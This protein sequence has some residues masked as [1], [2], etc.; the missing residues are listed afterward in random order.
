MM[1]LNFKN[2]IESVL[3]LSYDPNKNSTKENFFDF[4][5]L[6]SM[7]M[8]SRTGEDDIS[9]TID[10]FKEI[11]AKWW[12]KTLLEDV[13]ECIQLEGRHIYNQVYETK[14][15][16]KEILIKNKANIHD[17]QS[18]KREVV[19]RTYKILFKELNWESSYGGKAWYDVCVL[20]EKLNNEN[21]IN[22][23]VFLTDR[24][25]D[26]EHN[27]DALLTKLNKYITWI[28]KALDFKYEVKNVREYQDYI[29]PNIEKLLLRYTKDRN[30]N[31]TTEEKANYSLLS[32]GKIKKHVG[33]M[34]PKD[35]YD[36]ALNNNMPFPDGEDAISKIP[37]FSYN[38][39]R[40]VIKGPFPKGEDAIATNAAYSFSYARSVIKGP[41]PKGE[42]A[43]SKDSYYSYLYAKNILKAP[44]PKGEKEIERTGDF[45]YEYIKMFPNSN[46][47]QKYKNTAS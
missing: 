43:I 30:I 16:I 40:Y 26:T 44:F 14:D 8:P 37:D 24:I 1:Q 33:K 25:F 46:L 28:K 45:K 9:H 18:Q 23:I 15:E 2:F 22:Q 29:S 3:N 32:K 38:Y 7:Y 41:F 11:N 34:E 35:A 4:Y 17:L 36:Y 47:A 42:D 19:V 5:A 20:W 21:N 39:A 27:T 10:Y 12:K 13:Y 6:N 31:R